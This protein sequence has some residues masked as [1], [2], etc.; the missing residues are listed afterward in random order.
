M[1]YQFNMVWDPRP[2][3]ANVPAPVIRDAVPMGPDGWCAANFDAL[4][5]TCDPWD[6]QN[7]NGGTL[8]AG[9]VIWS[10]EA[11]DGC[12]GTGANPADC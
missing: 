1:L 6:V 9:C 12:T 10:W 2:E 3:C 4:T 5:N 11:F 8:Y 7:R